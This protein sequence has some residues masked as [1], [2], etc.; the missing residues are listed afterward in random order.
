MGGMKDAFNSYMDMI[1]S[2]GD[3]ESSESIDDLSDFDDIDAGDDLDICRSIFA[4][5]EDSLESDEAEKYSWRENY[6][7]DF[8]YNIDPEDY[9]TEEEYLDAL[10]E[11]HLDVDKSECIAK[12]DLSGTISTEKQRKTNTDLSMIYDYCKVSVDR[13]NIQY[14]F[15]PGELELSISDRVLVPLGS[16]NKYAI[17]TV[18]AV[19]KCL[20]SVFPCDIKEMKTVVR[21]LDKHDNF[22]EQTTALKKDAKNDNLVYEDSYI[23][24]TFVKWAHQNYLVGG[25][26]R[27]ATFIFENKYDKRFCIYLKD[28]SVAGFLN[29]AESWTVALSGKQKELKE[30]PL[31]YEDRVPEFS[32]EYSTIEFKVCYG[33]IKDGMSSIHLINKPI[34]ESEIISIKI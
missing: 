11:A 10:E 18:V 30:M 25:H 16:D 21:L 15:L 12:Q 2:S 19:G 6:D 5:K 14:D 24:I 8:D 34:I 27:T 1:L 29:Q 3:K 22:Q 9:E 31:V 32:K 13:S 17:G 33:T 26:A 20:S 4:A 23:K 7:Y 28:I